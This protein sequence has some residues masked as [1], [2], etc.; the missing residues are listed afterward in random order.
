L[1][2]SSSLLTGQPVSPKAARKTHDSPPSHI[3]FAPISKDNSPICGGIIP[4][5]TRLALRQRVSPAAINQPHHVRVCS[6]PFQLLAPSPPQYDRFVTRRRKLPVQ[7]SCTTRTSC[8]TEAQWLASNLLSRPKYPQLA[9]PC[10]TS[11][12]NLP[13]S[14]AVHNTRYLVP[15]LYAASRRF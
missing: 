14:P 8:M 10:L 12:L 6:R 11:L 15:R 1:H 7:P 4:L 2:S 13:T 5:P 3:C 9:L